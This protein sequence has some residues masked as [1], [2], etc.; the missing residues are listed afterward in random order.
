M[1]NKRSGHKWCNEVEMRSVQ[2]GRGGIEGRRRPNTGF[3]IGPTCGRGEGREGEQRAAAQ[4]EPDGGGMG[5][6]SSGQREL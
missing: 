4:R 6:S 5:E 2:L 3:T 1:E